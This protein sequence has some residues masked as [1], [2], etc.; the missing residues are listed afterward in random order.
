MSW[1]MAQMTGLDEI[2][3][4]FKKIGDKKVAS[5]HMGSALRKAAKPALDALKAIT[6]KGPTSNLRKSI[7]IT[8]RN[9]WNQGN[10][11]AFVEH[12]SSKRLGKLGMH[13]SILEHGT[14]PRFT[15]KRFAS[16]FKKR[17]AFAI[18]QKKVAKSGKNK[19]KVRFT[20]SP[21]YPKAFFKSAPLDKKVALGTGPALHLV[22]RAYSRSL[23]QIQ[24][25]LKKELT[26]AL[27]KAIAHAGFAE[28]T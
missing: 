3:A 22:S 21:K 15:K 8:V 19:G 14:K 20:T 2:T 10:A 23:P 16:S 17:G 9:Y 24:T 25:A 4:Q 18:N 7:Q 28:G 27:G 11:A 13:S 1:V 12:K 5:L 6:P 26:I